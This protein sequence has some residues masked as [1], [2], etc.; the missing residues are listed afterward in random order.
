VGTDPP[1]NRSANEEGTDRLFFSSASADDYTEVR[2]PQ[3][4]CQSYGCADLYL[5]PTLGPLEQLQ[6]QRPGHLLQHPE[7]QPQQQLPHQEQLQQQEH[8]QQAQL[9][10]QEQQRKSKNASVHS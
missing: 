9:A 4:P 8:P 6:L 7:Q 10:Q 2:R 3:R 5:T 1:T